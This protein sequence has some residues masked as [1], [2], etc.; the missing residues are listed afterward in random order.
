MVGFS[1]PPETHSKRFQTPLRI[2]VD[3]LADEGLTNAQ[4]TNAR[5]I[6][7]RLDPA[8]FHISTFYFNQP[9]PGIKSRPNTRLIQLPKRRQTIRILR[10]FIFGRYKI[11]FYM[12]SAPASKFYLRLRETWK[13]DRITIGTIESQS[14][15]GNEPTIRPEGIKMWEQTVLR[16]DFLFSNAQAVKRSLQSEYGLLSEVVET[17]VNTKFFM[18]DMERQRNARPRVL[19]AG[20]LRPF[21]QPHLM[22]EGARRFPEADFVV[23]GGGIMA[24][25]LREAVQYQNLPNVFLLGSLAAAALRKEYQRADIFMFPSKWEGSPKV[26]LEAAACGLPVLARKD[27][28]PETVIDGETGYLVECDSQLYS[29]LGELLAKEGLRN[30]LGSAGRRHSEKFDWDLITLKWESIFLR[31]ASQKQTAA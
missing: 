7:L 25:E 9:D 15:V 5:E 31:L 16:C 29:R 11:L 27:Y 22:L 14:D 20:S 12:K 18:P 17:G 6:I 8:K 10:E 3:S 30:R 1:A 2:L 21:K 24:D 28:N 4:M 26:I 19:F 23:A 13:D